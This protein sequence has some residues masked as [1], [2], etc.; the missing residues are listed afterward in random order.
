[1]LELRHIQMP[2]PLLKTDVIRRSRAFATRMHACFLGAAIRGLMPSDWC[3]NCEAAGSRGRRRLALCAP[4]AV[5]R[6]GAAAHRRAVRQAAGDSCLVARRPGEPSVLLRDCV[7]TTLAG[8]GGNASAECVPANS[9]LA[10]HQNTPA[11]PSRLAPRHAVSWMDP[12]QEEPST[13]ATASILLQKLVDSAAFRELWQEV[14]RRGLDGMGTEQ[15][16]LMQVHQVSY[17]PAD[18][19]RMRFRD[20]VILQQSC[21]RYVPASGRNSSCHGSPVQYPAANYG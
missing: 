20:V 6:P 8:C 21:P 12:G 18:S 3:F 17:A 19:S 11:K 14:G 1:V 5:A 7:H 4:E 15:K 16:M 2:L 13:A 10:G 9:S